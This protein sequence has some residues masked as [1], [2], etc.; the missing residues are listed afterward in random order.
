MTNNTSAVNPLL[1]E[2]DRTLHDN[3]NAY[4]AQRMSQYMRNKF[5]YFGI[6]SQQRK[7]LAKPFIKEHLSSLNWDFV[8]AC[9]DQNYREYQYIALDYL[10]HPR[11]TKLLAYDDHKH[12]R[13]LVE[14]KTWWD[15]TDNLT[16]PIGHT[17]LSHRIF[18]TKLMQSWAEDPNMWIRRT[19]ILHQLSFRQNTDVQLL[20][21]AIIKNLGTKEFFIN[22]AIGWALRDYNKTNPIWVQRYVQTNF[23][24]MSRLTVR[25]A[26]KYV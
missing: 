7:T 6:H 8:N 23:S 22:K 5:V 15:T 13:K 11:I 3:A 21:Y 4:E 17:I 9:W 26:T 10:K 24:L 14:T 1:T 18:G 2:L 20:D 12:L 25:E 16:K 19:A